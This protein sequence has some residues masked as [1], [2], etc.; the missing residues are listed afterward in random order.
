MN[1]IQKL[2]CKLFNIEIQQEQPIIINNMVVEVNK[3]GD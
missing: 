2:V 1:L 3:K